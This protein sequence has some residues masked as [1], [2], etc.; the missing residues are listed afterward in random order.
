M[1]TTSECRVDGCSAP[2]RDK[3]RQLC[4]AHRQRLRAY[5]S[6]GG[7][8]AKRGGTLRERLEAKVSVRDEDECWPYGAGLQHGYGII[9]DGKKTLKAHRVAYSL[10]VGEIP[11]GHTI[12]HECHNRALEAGECSGGPCHHRS[13]CNPKH[14][15]P[16]LMWDNVSRGDSVASINSRKTHCF[17]GHELPEDRVCRE[18]KRIATAEWVA[19]NPERVR[20]NAAAYRARDPE[21]AREKSRRS[22][23]RIAYGLSLE[24]YDELLAMQGGHCAICPAKEAGRAGR[25]DLYVDYCPD[26][27][28]VRGLLCATCS[29]GISRFRGD[30]VLLQAAAQYATLTQGE[31]PGG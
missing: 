25:V 6:P 5:G 20:E 9:S 1:E 27:Q 7:R 28:R 4:N 31:N 8:P 12:D 21:R 2:I 16:R 11:P 14:L 3:G 24:E 19:R 22:K 17:R 29:D 26:T 30:P 15:V 23:L 18:C 10:W 13:C